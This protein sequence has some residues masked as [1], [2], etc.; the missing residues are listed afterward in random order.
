[1]NRRETA[2]ICDQYGIVAKKRFSQNFLCNSQFTE[3]I[4][5]SAGISKNDIVLE[6]GPGTGA[7]T[8]LLCQVSSKVIAVEIDQD[9]VLLLNNRFEKNDNLSVVLG[10]YLKLKRSSLFNADEYPSIIVS[11]LPYNVTTPMIIKLL[12]DFPES[13]TMV[14]MIEEDACDRL[15]AGPGEKSYGVL[16]VI[17]S[18]YGEKEKLF[19]V[20]SDSFF[21]APHTRSAVVR[22]SKSPNQIP[23]TD[24]YIQFVK[25][26]FSKR[27]KTLINSL[28]SFPRNEIAGKSLPAILSEM[29]LSKT[30]RAEALTHKELISIFSVL[31]HNK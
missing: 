23:V 7:M 30:V 29:N 13:C 4:I 19:L 28:S 18:S 2:S 26:A 9:L 20:D 5:D 6:I 3:K 27:R 24:A 14:F 25:D 15:F 12:S 22:F 11:N 16:S 10:D 1:M 8:A 17:T 21:P 31:E